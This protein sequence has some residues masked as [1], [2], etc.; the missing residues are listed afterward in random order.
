MIKDMIKKVVMGE[1]LTQHEIVDVMREIMEGRATPA[2]I[3]SFLTALRIK[4]ETIDEITGAARVMREK[5]LKI[6]V[7]IEMLVDTC[8]T[9]GDNSGSFNVST[10]VGFVVAGAGLSVAKHGNRSVSSLSGSADVMEALGVN[11]DV[12]P[13]LVERCIK[14][15][16]IGFLY[17]PRF[18]SAMKYAKEPRTE[19]GIRT[20]FNILGPLTNPAGANV[21]VLG[22]YES[23]L[24]EK[25]AYVLRNLGSKGALV[26]H[27]VGG[28]DEITTIA[29]T[30]VSQ[31]KNGSVST[32]YINAWDF[33]LER[34]SIEAIRGGDAK[35]N[36][37][38]TLDILNGQ[39]GAKRDM[40]VL[41]AA[42][43]FLAADVVTTFEE[44]IEMARDSID[45]G[46]AMEKLNQLIQMTRGLN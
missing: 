34:S 36:A 2:Q 40:V 42:A 29:E 39:K 17:A 10:T 44:G 5:A 41:N 28:L 18:H 31:L 37:Q 32:Y 12:S 16:G 3:G 46:K 25:I 8:G 38:I 23:S 13:E 22:V 27:G 1:D 43:A 24:T 19:I 30:K 35:V 33:G 26:V 14:E 7:G 6:D 20:I 4:G 21:Q 45:T 15:I 9:G 11:I